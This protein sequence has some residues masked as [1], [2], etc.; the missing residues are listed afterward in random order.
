MIIGDRLRALRE[1]RKLSQGDIERLTSLMR[2]YISR[3]ENGHITPAL[4]TLEKMA[5]ALEVPLYALFYDAEEP[6]HP[7]DL[8]QGTPAAE[9]T[10]G[11][12]GEDS[13]TL[14]QF[15]RLLSRVKPDDQRLLLFMANK[16]ALRKTPRPRRAK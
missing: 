6:P 3:V 13:R 4:G 10:W 7:P 8:P 5:R 11:S 9:A 14:A 15:R 16:M 2:P 1:E 12:S